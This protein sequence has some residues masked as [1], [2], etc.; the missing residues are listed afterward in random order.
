MGEHA[1]EFLNAIADE[2]QHQIARWGDDVAEGKDG[3]FF[4]LLLIKQF[5]QL[6]DTY[7]ANDVA[8]FE[9]RMTREAQIEAREALKARL[10]QLSAVAAAAYEACDRDIAQYADPH[11][12][13]LFVGDRAD[14]EETTD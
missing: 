4:L 2:R 6:G 14:Q 13:V 11:V 9:R 10:V 12:D 1:Q 3:F 8:D 5:G 7:I